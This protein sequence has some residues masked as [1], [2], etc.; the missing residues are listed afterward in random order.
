MAKKHSSAK[1]S[2]SSQQWL[3]RQ[4]SDEYT[5][6]AKQEGYR[7]R[8]VYKLEEIQAKDKVFR[9]GMTVVDL[10]AAPGSWSQL[11]AKYIGKQ[12]RI[13]AIDILPI[14]HIPNVEI[15]EGDFKQQSVIDEL[16]QR[17]GSRVDLII[18]DIA[19][20]FSGDSNVDMPSAMYLA[21]LALDFAQ[22]VLVTKG[23]MVIK[24]FQGA[25]FLEFT[26]LLK[27]NF[28]KVIIRKPKAS[29]R[30]SREVYAVAQDYQGK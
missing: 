4:H 13:I 19:P 8:A 10:G 3:D 28:A 18:S 7:S 11:A 2:K 17:S 15:I 24:L 9:P 12:G 14:D 30:E 23:C 20:N 29:R 26:Q 1:R 16:I 5:R 27:Q 22:Q 21:E 25:G 6:R